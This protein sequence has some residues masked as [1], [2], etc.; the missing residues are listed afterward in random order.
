MTMN[1]ARPTNHRI[2]VNR[3]K[4]I[5]VIGINATKRGTINS[6]KKPMMIRPITPIKPTTNKPNTLRL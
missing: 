2:P 4:P 5:S 6:T 3:N 1:D